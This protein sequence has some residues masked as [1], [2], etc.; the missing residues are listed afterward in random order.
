MPCPASKCSIGL[1]GHFRWALLL[2]K[3]PLTANPAETTEAAMPLSPAPFPRVTRLSSPRTRERRD[4]GLSPVWTCAVTY[5]FY[6]ESLSLK[7]PQEPII[8]GDRTRVV[9]IW[10]NN[11]AQSHF[12]EC[13]WNIALALRKTIISV[14][15][16]ATPLPAALRALHAIAGSDIE[17]ACGQFFRPCTSPHQKQ[18]RL[19]GQLCLNS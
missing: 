19:T 12:V 11:A 14:L 7:I 15:L 6:K 4:C 13:E 5:C 18:T 8:S 17:A 3:Q 10:S 1:W 9:L 2:N 16:D